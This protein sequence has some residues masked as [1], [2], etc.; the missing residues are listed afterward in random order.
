MVCDKI[1][2]KYFTLDG[3]KSAKSIYREHRILSFQMHV[4][5]SV[6]IRIAFDICTNQ[7]IDCTFTIFLTA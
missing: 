4:M 6:L 7:H 5:L 3:E 2:R 1:L